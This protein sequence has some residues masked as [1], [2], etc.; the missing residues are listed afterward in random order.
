MEWKNYRK[1]NLLNN[2]I[3]LSLAKNFF[4]MVSVLMET[5]VS[6]CIMKLNSK[7]NTLNIC[8]ILIFLKIFL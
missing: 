1:K 6:I 4:L 3:K 7:R 2:N 5:A 8:K